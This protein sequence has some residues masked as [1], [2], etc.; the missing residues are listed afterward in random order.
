MTD[1]TDIQFGLHAVLSVLETDYKRVRDVIILKDRKD[2]RIQKVIDAARQH[3]IKIR[4]QTRADFER[5]LKNNDVSD[6][7]HQGVIAQC[8]AMDALDEG[9]LE[10]LLHGLQEPALLVVLDGVTDPHNLGAVL[11]TAEAAGAHAVIAPKDKSASLTAT[12]IKVASGAAAKVPFIQVTNLARTLKY[13]QQSGVWII[14]TAGEAEQNLHQAK[15]TGAMALV[16]GAEGDGMR[17]LTRETC[18][19]LIFI[20][21]QGT[22]SSLNVSVATGVC[23]FEIVRQRMAKVPA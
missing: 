6:A 4:F 20:P 10:T 3:A 14:G 18:D 11:R 1:K 21:M 13:L 17:R 19:E 22:V 16:M 15:L 8:T 2:Q 5:L 12:A 9:D 7:R 23:L